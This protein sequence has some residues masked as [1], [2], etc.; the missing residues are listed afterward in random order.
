MRGALWAES[1]GAR[2]AL[3]GARLARSACLLARRPR[4]GACAAPARRGS[5]NESVSKCHNSAPVALRIQQRSATAEIGSGDQQHVAR[6]LASAIHARSRVSSNVFCGMPAR[7]VRDEVISSAVARAVV[8]A[9]RVAK[10]ICTGG[11]QHGFAACNI[12][13]QSKRCLKSL[14]IQA[15]PHGTNSCCDSE[16][17]VA[18]GGFRHVRHSAALAVRQFLDG[19]LL[20]Q[21]GTVILSALMT[22]CG[23]GRSFVA[24]LSD[25][26]KS[27]G[28]CAVSKAVHSSTSRSQASVPP[29]LSQVGDGWTSSRETPRSREAAGAE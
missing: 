23:R 1:A 26:H 18:M 20:K 22:T 19:R 9:N 2:S 29:K 14:H 8:L 6:P 16:D 15:E 11:F 3:R 13:V 17:T 28:F 12:P 10:V 7:S 24:T 21:S 4:R 27:C 25:T 5:A